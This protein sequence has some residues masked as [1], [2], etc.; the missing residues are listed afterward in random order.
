MTLAIKNIK[1]IHI[2]HSIPWM[3]IVTIQDCTFIHM[4]LPLYL[5]FDFAHTTFET[6]LFRASSLDPA[7]LS[8]SL[9]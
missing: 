5:T 6:H 3:T 7:F 2:I 4:D 9:I 1:Y 8:L